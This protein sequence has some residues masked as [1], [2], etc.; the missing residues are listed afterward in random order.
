[1]LLSESRPKRQALA[2]IGGVVAGT[3]G[4]AGWAIAKTTAVRNELDKTESE[5]KLLIQNV[6]AASA[7]G[8]AAV[9]ALKSLEREAYVNNKL[10]STLEEAERFQMAAMVL[11]AHSQR[12]LT[13]VKALLGGRLSTDLAEENE[14]HEGISNLVQRAREKGLR[15]LKTTTPEVLNSQV[16]YFYGDGDISAVIHIP[17]TSLEEEPWELFKFEPLPVDVNGT[18]YEIRPTKRYLAMDKEHASYVELDGHVLD[19]CR[20]DNHDFWCS[21]T[22]PRMRSPRGG[23]LPALFT[24]HQAE[25]EALCPCEELAESH[26]ARMVNDTTV[27]LGD[28]T[29]TPYEVSCDDGHFEVVKVKGLQLLSLNRGC[30]AVSEHTEVPR[31]PRLTSLSTK[32]HIPGPVY[33]EKWIKPRK[34]TTYNI[35]KLLQLTNEAVEQTRKMEEALTRGTPR[36]R[37]WLGPVG[38]A[39]FISIL[40]CMVT[41]SLKRTKSCH[42]WHRRN[43]DDEREEDDEEPPAL[44]PEE[45]SDEDEETSF[46]SAEGTFTI[47]PSPAQNVPKV[48]QRDTPASKRPRTGAAGNTPTGPKQKPGETAASQPAACEQK[49]VLVVADQADRPHRGDFSDLY[50]DGQYLDDILLRVKPPTADHPKPVLQ[51]VIFPRGQ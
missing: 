15:L 7:N 31:L 33:S 5:Q 44:I 26:L 19:H 47:P 29:E 8:V 13:A 32:V 42:R 6:K 51:K 10:F 25:I 50:V 49:P 30:T 45:P 39:I 11:L 36:A 35:S 1:M 37:T 22:L 17:T 4:L 43:E 38:F 40:A 24:G 27:L 23:C 18:W 12:K 34:M 16:S 14:I 2:I 46:V 9:K 21:T 48:I 3:A 28:K 41:C 20:N